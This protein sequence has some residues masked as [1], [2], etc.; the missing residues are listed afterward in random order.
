M[1]KQREDGEDIRIELGSEEG[2]YLGFLGYINDLTSAFVKRKGDT[3][4]S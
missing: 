3:V 1:D 4:Q 2:D